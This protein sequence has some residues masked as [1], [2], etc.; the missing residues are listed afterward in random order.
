LV[1]KH[2]DSAEAEILVKLIQK[3][4]NL[5]KNSSVLDMACGAGRHSI[6]FAQKGFNVTA[7]DLSERLISEAKKNAAQAKVTVD[8]LLTD[9]RD[10]RLDRQFDLVVNLFT[11]FGYFESDEEN[12]SVFQK[13]YDLIKSG[14]YFVLDY[15]NS[16]RLEKY[17][18][19]TSIFSKNGTTIKQDRTIKGKR[20][21]KK[22]TIEKDDSIKHFHE[23]VR[24]Y[25][26]S[27]IK[28]ILEKTGFRIVESFGDFDGNI[29]EQNS[30]KRLII[31][32][33]K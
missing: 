28:S 16:I 17:L 3:N 29:F 20:V 33:Q 9:I 2:R 14:G 24:L 5:L 13:A 10:L 19:P 25:D 27:E 4:L 22:I 15:L 8:F 7:V 26:Y 31:F 21:E 6:T 11:S 32:A 18:V 1:Y 23:S 30:S 12:F